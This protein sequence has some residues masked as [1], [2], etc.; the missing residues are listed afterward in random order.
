[1]H[2]FEL[3][4]LVYKETQVRKIYGIVRLC[5]KRSK[6]LQDGTPDG[7][8]T[9]L[10]ECNMKKTSMCMLTPATGRSLEILSEKM[11]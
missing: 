7:S 8:L 1:M 11:R 9:T 4:S 10:V 5:A 2:R 3:I 6:D